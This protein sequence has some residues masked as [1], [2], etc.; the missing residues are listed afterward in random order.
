VKIIKRVTNEGISYIDDSG[1][2]GYVDFKQ[3]NENW[4]QYR[5]RSE[6]L[7]EERVIALRK[8][9]KCVG[10]RDICAR[11]RFIEFFTK[12]FTR[13]EFIECDEYPDAEKAFCKLQNDIISAGWT[14][15]DLS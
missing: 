13:F 6:N 7:S 2:Q 9:S 12:P 4:I 3:C 10:Q 5:K 1:S 8:R 15:L 11:P 14:T